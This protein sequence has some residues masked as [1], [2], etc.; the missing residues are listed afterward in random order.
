MD[1]QRF[2]EQI[3]DDES[4]T[5]GVADDEAQL[6]TEWAIR[7]VEA[8]VAAAA[9]VEAARAATADVRR[10]CRAV[11]AVVAAIYYEDDLDAAARQWTGLGHDQDLGPL[12]GLPVVDGVKQLLDWETELER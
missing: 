4:L 7:Q 2:V 10:R 12:A 5:D 11:A 8:K 9:D 3:L 6:L 1:P